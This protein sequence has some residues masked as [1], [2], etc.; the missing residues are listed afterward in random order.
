MDGQDSGTSSGVGYPMG[1]LDMWTGQDNGSSL[2][3]EGWMFMDVHWKDGLDRTVGQHARLVRVGCPLDKW[4]GL[5]SEASLVSDDGRSNRPLSCQ[6]HLS[7]GCLLDIHWTGGLDRTLDIHLTGGLDR[8]V[9]PALSARLGSSCL[10]DQ[11][12][13]SIG[14]VD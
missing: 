1:V 5:D 14:Q 4:T 3:S 10:I 8:T 2:V 9:G 6:V 7:N 11:Q 13:K 12:W